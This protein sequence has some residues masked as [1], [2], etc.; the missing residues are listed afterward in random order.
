MIKIDTFHYTNQYIHISTLKNEFMCN[1][2]WITYSQRSKNPG[3]FNDFLNI[4]MKR[5]PQLIKVLWEPQIRSS[6]ASWLWWKHKSWPGKWWRF[7]VS[8]VSSLHAGENLLDPQ[9]ADLNTQHLCRR[10]VFWCW[11][12]FL[13]SPEW[14]WQWHCPQNRQETGRCE[15]SELGWWCWTGSWDSSRWFSSV[16]FDILHSQD[17]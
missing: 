11:N 5:P 8:K 2:K 3:I 17:N 9:P 13:H 7:P 1:N 15:R 14:C 10:S 4:D 6:R 12:S 16:S